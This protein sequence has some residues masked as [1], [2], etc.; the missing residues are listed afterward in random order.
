MSYQSSA[1]LQRNCH[2]TPPSTDLLTPI[3]FFKLFH[4]PVIPCFSAS[5]IFLHNI[6][7]F[8]L[9]VSAQWG[10]FLRRNNLFCF[11]SSKTIRG[12]SNMKG[13]S[14]VGSE[15][16]KSLTGKKMMDMFF[17]FLNMLC[18]FLKTHF[19]NVFSHRALPEHSKCS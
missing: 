5:P 1:Y 11:S 18:I 19:V 7:H 8:I 15:G 9:Y 14:A 10:D 2:W 12:A 16:H 6:T 3:D 4:F 13:N 17:C